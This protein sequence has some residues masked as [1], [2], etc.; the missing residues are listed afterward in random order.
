MRVALWIVP[1]LLAGVRPASAQ[2]EFAGSWT[3]V[4]TAL[5]GGNSAPVDYMGIQLNDEGRSRS[6]TYSQSRLSMPE[7]QCMGWAPGYLL[8]GIFAMR[9]WPEIDPVTGDTLAFTIGGWA[10]R[11]PITIWMDGRPHPSPYAVH[12]RA[13]FATGRWEDNRLVVSIT[14]LNANFIGVGPPMSDEA[15]ITMRFTRRSSLLMIVAVLDDPIYLAEPYVISAVFENVPQLGW[16]AGPP[17][18]IDDEGVSEGRV[19]HYLPGKNP[20]VDEVTQK[21]HIPREAVLGGADTVYP[22]YRK[23]IKDE[24]LSGNGMKR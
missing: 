16:A 8:R 13:G 20:F 19:P 10:D 22:E 12:E 1:L 2:F 14:H 5:N 23:K 11:A 15:T 21:T 24:Y 3:R 6:L 4:S 17:C 18:I 7:R 9:V